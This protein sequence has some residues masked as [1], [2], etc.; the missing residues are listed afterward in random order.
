MSRSTRI[1]EALVCRCH[2]RS[3]GMR[4]KGTGFRVSIVIKAP[5]AFVESM[6]DGSFMRLDVDQR[7]ESTNKTT[8]VYCI[9][10]DS[11]MTTALSAKYSKK[12]VCISFVSD[13]TNVS[14]PRSH[15]FICLCHQV[16]MGEEEIDKAG[17]AA[18]STYLCQRST[19]PLHIVMI[20]NANQAR[21]YEPRRRT[22]LH[23]KS[24]TE[25]SSYSR[26]VQ[27]RTKLELAP[28]ALRNVF[29]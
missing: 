7:T 22:I 14:V 25:L 19:D 9:C 2:V 16:E 4:S 23:L 5:H 29:F 18:D 26:T 8:L 6:N 28:K 24:L 20:M 12:S 1:R 11:R 3:E 13:R 17:E 15:L 21:D 27:A 10:S